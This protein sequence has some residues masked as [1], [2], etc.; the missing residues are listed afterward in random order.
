MLSLKSVS[1]C[2]FLAFESYKM[3]PLI[4]LCPG[5]S[6][7]LNYHTRKREVKRLKRKTK[8][9][10]SSSKSAKTDVQLQQSPSTSHRSQSEE[11][12][13][14]DDEPPPFETR[15]IQEPIDDESLWKKNNEV[16]VKGRDEEFDDYLADLLL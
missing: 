1:W 7:K 4:G 11:A 10:S 2:K 6:D 16:D 14:V 13:P 12:E 8:R 15:S 3:I 5:C 9:K